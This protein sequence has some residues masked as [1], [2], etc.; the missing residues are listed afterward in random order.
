MHYQSYCLNFKQNNSW[1]DDLR[2]AF[3][4]IFSLFKY[5]ELNINN[6]ESINTATKK[7]PFFATKSYV[8]KIE[9]RNAND[10][11]LL[12]IIPQLQE[13]Q[14][15][16]NYSD[17]PVGD[18]DARVASTL[19]HKYHGRVLIHTTQ[20]CAINCRFCFRK[21]SLRDKTTEDNNLDDAFNYINH[22]P[23]I[24]E[25]ILSGGEPLMLSDHQLKKIFQ[26]IEAIPHIT[27]IRIHS[28]ILSTLPSRITSELLH[29]FNN[30]RLHKILVTH[31]NH[32]NEID[33]GLCEAVKSI[34]DTNTTIL[35]QSVLLKDIN[36]TAATQIDL[37]KNLFKSGILPYYLHTLDKATG[38][39]HFYIPDAEARV[40]WK[41]MHKQLPGYLVPKLVKEI[42]GEQGKTY[43]S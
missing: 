34:K 15:T 14:A 38:T 16:E 32:P 3:T 26:R 31:V 42:T 35:N 9:K 4:D 13:L 19:L 2:D 28:R 22:S 7:Y 20:R 12:Q 25:V 17:D 43:L 29:I 33:I 6:A 27:S 1:Q 18:N 8:N 41:Q 11:L 37:S 23:D 39:C 10:P 36:A 40:I 30:T 5:L 24:Y 21:N